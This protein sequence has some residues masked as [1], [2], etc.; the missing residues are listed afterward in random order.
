[1]T[2]TAAPRTSAA[3]PTEDD[4]ADALTLGR[5]IRER[6]AQLGLT[7]EQLATAIDRA[8]SQLSAIENGKREPR[9]PILR[10]LAAALDCTVD[11][12]LADEA[13]SERAALEISV[14][15]AQRGSVFRSLGIPAIRVS[16]ATSDDTLK[17]ILGLHQ[18]VE[19]LHRE[20]AATPEEA[21]RA[22]TELRAEMRVRGN[23]FAELEAEAQRLLGAVG[24]SGGPVSQR[25]IAQVAEKL[26]FSLHYVTDL[27][28]STRSVIDR[29]N[30][31]IYL[32]ANLPSRDA[33]APILR[34]LASLVCRHEEPRNYGDFLR[35]RVE[36]NYLAGAVLLPEDA[37][38]ELLA[39]AKRERQISMEDLRDAFAVSYEMAAHRFTN[40]ATERLDL[41]VHFMKAHESGTLIKA[42]ENDGVRFPSDAL[43]NLEGATVC[44][45]WTA[46][47]V[48]AQPDR[49][50]P[51]Y[52]YTDMAAGGTYW[53]TSRVEKAKEGEYS[54][55]VG[56]PFDA[57]KWFR[58]RE[59][60]HRSTSD[61]PDERCCRRASDGLTRKW[62]SVAWPEAATPTSL[63]A[64][65]PTGTFPGVDAHEVYEFLE[66][67]EVR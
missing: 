55:S 23:Y 10:A 32:G 12:L 36:A 22:N 30:G 6:R 21:R 5:R 18:E 4:T 64:A 7:L 49:F 2:L 46:R 1:M 33:R 65:L 47:T 26:G 14:E 34:A 52:Q 40:L 31:R 53:C 39:E 54:V 66:A 59:T 56:V 51:W 20:R 17:A 13:P 15:R 57:V 35:Q 44:R 19:R 16:K 9:L 61:C 63:L 8:P 43:G 27:P 42:Y 58:G 37:T 41:E 38:V 60:S 28:H 3:E 45:N 50:N 62:E 48:F 24:Y 29:R 25:T 67:N 11:E